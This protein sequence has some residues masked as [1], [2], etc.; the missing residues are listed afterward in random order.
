M[1]SRVG[2]YYSILLKGYRGFTQGDPLS[3]TIYNMMVYAVISN[4]VTVVVWEEA[5]PYLCEGLLQRVATLFYEIYGLL[6]PTWT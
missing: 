4:W 6:I 2:Q 5:E 3:P 1:V